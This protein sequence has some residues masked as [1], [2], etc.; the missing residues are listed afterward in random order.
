MVDKTESEPELARLI[1][2]TTLSVIAEMARQL[3]ALLIHYSI[4][5]VFDGS[6]DTPR[7]ERAAVGPLSIYGKSKLEGEDLIRARGC[8][9]LILRASWVYAMRGHNSIKTML[10]VAAERD[11]RCNH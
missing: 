9:H 4:D 10:R 1:N 5:Y 7:D 2:A 8:R 3:D 6:G 11:S